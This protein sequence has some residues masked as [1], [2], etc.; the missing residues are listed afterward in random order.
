MTAF[1]RELSCPDCGRDYLLSGTITN[2][3][4][5]T[6]ALAQVRCS[7]GY[8]MGV[9]IP[10]SVPRARLIVTL[11]GRPEREEPQ[12]LEVRAPHARKK[13]A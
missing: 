5:E 1:S 6:E 4:S 8:W 13:T 12:V 9:F 11:S 10:S 7:C 2:T 3:A